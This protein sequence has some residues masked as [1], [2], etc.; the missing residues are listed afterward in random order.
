M[1]A[2]LVFGCIA[3]IVVFGVAG[4]FLY[5][6]YTKKINTPVSAPKPAPAPAPKPAPAPVTS[7]PPAGVS[8][9]KKV[10]TIGSSKL[11]YS[12]TTCSDTEDADKKYCQFSSIKDAENDC[13]NSNDCTGY[14][15]TDNKSYY[16]FSGNTKDDK[17]STFWKKS[18]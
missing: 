12:K 16:L 3:V 18:S 1:N 6:W 17:G 13:K 15:T 2:L 7:S 8:W 4:Y 10:D 11:A 9:F 14:G 5:G